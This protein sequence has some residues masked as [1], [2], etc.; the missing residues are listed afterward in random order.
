MVALTSHR[1]AIGS[2]VFGATLLLVACHGDSPPLGHADAGPKPSAS[3]P[4]VTE[5]PHPPR[6]L[7][8][9]ADA[10][11][12]C[13]IDHDGQVIDLGTDA[14]EGRVGWTQGPPRGGERVEHDGSTWL[15]ALEKTITV[16]FV[17]TESSPLFVAVRAMGH[18]AKRAAVL[19]DDQA[20]GTLTMAHEE[21]RVSTTP[22]TNLPVDPGYHTLKIR[23]SG[24]P[25]GESE[26]Y[27]DLDWIRI[28]TGSR[29]GGPAYGAPTLRDIDAPAAAIG[30]VPHRSIALRAPSSVRCALRVTSGARVKA[31][32][33]LSGSG[34]G[35]A[36]IRLVSD[37]RPPETLAKLAIDGAAWKDADLSLDG[38]AGELVA[39]E[40]RATSNSGAGR[41]LFGDAAIVATAN[42]PPPTPS[43][44]GAVVVVLDGVEHD[45]LPPYRPGAS[46]MLPTL[47]ELALVGTAFDAHRAPSPVVAASVASLLTGLPPRAHAVI[48]ATSRLPSSA[49]T[50]AAL[51][52]EASVRTAMFTGVPH[53]FRPFGFAEGWSRFAEHTPS[54]GDPAS[55]P[56][57]DATAWITELVRDVPDGRYLAVVHARGGHPPWDVSAKDLAALSPADYSG[58]IEPRRAAQALAKLRQR[59]RGTTALAQPDRDRVRALEALALAGED[60]AIGGL[61][62]ALK[63]ANLWDSTLFVVTGDVAVGAG[64]A[65]PFTSTPL[66]EETALH[67]PLLVHFPGSA[68]GGTRVRRPTTVVD[69]TQTITSALGLKL[70]N[71]SARQDL[72]RVAAGLESL[73]PTI[74][75]LGDGYSVRWG[76]LV[77]SGKADAPPLL[78][79]LQLDP[80][81]AFNRRT[82]LPLSAFALF[83]RFTEL[84][85]AARSH[86][87]TRE[88]VTLG[89][90]IAAALDVWGALD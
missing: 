2:G 22:T 32:V 23:F 1:P 35:E 45:E 88:P 76:E 8:R 71:E 59:K 60:H 39:I 9:F 82:V 47:G 27:A 79:D 53:T 72:G 26:A 62:A 66:L 89:T 12:Q 13:D 65:V 4:I 25:R 74:A 58:P 56:I 29:D 83:H 61:V 57:D 18:G 37:G 16:S 85:L 31:S 24:H 87:E 78:C 41:V 20:L 38:H 90:D 28:G 63:A 5:A 46:A 36:E 50:L 44:R 69:L 51:A 40:L 81:C 54:S 42:N 34:Q 21:I 48:D 3:A 64:S 68:F 6:T 10:L 43:A 17:S 80:S 73:Q 52:G 67:L 33:G 75:T 19:L 86:A 11:P 77:L 14:V 15:R 70:A 7:L 84:D 55:A 30:G 49:R